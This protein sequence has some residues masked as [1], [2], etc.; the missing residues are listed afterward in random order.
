MR[1]NRPKKALASGGGP[2]AHEWIRCGGLDLTPSTTFILPYRRGKSQDFWRDLARQARHH[3]DVARRRGDRGR[4]EKH[5][6]VLE[7][8]SSRLIVPREK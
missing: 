6:R 5:L 7:S 2:P 1:N 4:V 8:I 3:A